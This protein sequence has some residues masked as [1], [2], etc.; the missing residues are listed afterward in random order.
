[1]ARYNAAMRVQPS[2]GADARDAE[3]GVFFVCPERGS[4]HLFKTGLV[5]IAGRKQDQQGDFKNKFI[6]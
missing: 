1:M 4:E 6:Y 2:S 3:C 5:W